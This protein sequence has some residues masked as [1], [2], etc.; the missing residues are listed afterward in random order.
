MTASNYNVYFGQ[1]YEDL[2]L[3]VSQIV[4]Q[5]I[6]DIDTTAAPGVIKN[7]GFGI[8][9]TA[10]QEGYFSSSTGQDTSVL[11]NNPQGARDSY[12][13]KKFFSRSSEFFF[14]RPTI[15]A[16][17]DS[18]VSDDRENFYYSSSLAP[19]A[20]NLNTL[21]LYNYIRGRLVNIP[22][23]GTGGILVSLY[24]G[25]T[26]PTG[27]ALTLYDGN[28]NLTGGYVSTGIYSASLAITA[29]ATPLQVLYD[30]LA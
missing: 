9:L 11:I 6:K 1:G 27:T 21:Y 19:A 2:G 13:I 23:V 20:D 10:S 4:E 12:Y 30:V 8:R 15:E 7:Y 22:A 29:A 17:W 18:R 28:L 26:A 24:S 16:R 25:S 14:K 5:W 3:D